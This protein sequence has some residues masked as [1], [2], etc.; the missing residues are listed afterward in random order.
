FTVADKIK[1]ITGSKLLVVDDQG[2]GHALD[3]KTGRDLATYPAA[4]LGRAVV[5]DGVVYATSHDGSVT[6]L[7][8]ADTLWAAHLPIKPNNV[9]EPALFAGSLYVFGDLE[10][11]A[12]TARRGAGIY[13]LDARTGALRWKFEMPGADLRTRM[14]QAGRDAV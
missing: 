10:D 1:Y 14:L 13:A 5:D 6:A 9:F 11:P 2:R 7:K 4:Q 12:T 3:P 8:G